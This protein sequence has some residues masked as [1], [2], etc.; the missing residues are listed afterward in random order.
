MAKAD[1]SRF[2]VR[3]LRD[4]LSREKD[5]VTLPIVRGLRFTNPQATQVLILPCL[6][7]PVVEILT[8]QHGIPR[9]NMRAAERD[10]W[11]WR[12][13]HKRPYLRGVRLPPRPM[14]LGADI[15]FVRSELNGRKLDFVYL[16]FFGQP[17]SETFT[18]LS[19]LM[20]YDML[21]RRAVVLITTLF[22][23]SKCEQSDF[24]KDVRVATSAS[25]SKTP[26]AKKAFAQLTAQYI[27]AAA[28]FTKYRRPTKLVP[29]TYKSLERKTGMKR[30]C[31]L[32]EARWS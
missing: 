13:M 26:A 30:T 11:V 10:Y 17:T 28:I 18:I 23:R 19:K 24:N 16:D 31:V 7:D 4:R 20:R 1:Y 5:A 25:D 15:D 27:T 6:A 22:T 2:T 12:K 32:T 8:D 29:H 21:A 3:R 14:S 9:E